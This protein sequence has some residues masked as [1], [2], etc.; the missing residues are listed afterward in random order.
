MLQGGR[1]ARESLGR[2]QVTQVLGDH[3]HKFISYVKG[4]GKRRVLSSSITQLSIKK[5]KHR[6][7][8]SVANG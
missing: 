5:L 2:G 4:N 7:N 8:L 6:Y 3:G 1:I